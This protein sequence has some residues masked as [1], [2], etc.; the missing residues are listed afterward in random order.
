MDNRAIEP[1]AGNTSSRYYYVAWLAL[2]AAGIFYVTIATLAPELLRGADTPAG[3]EATNAQVTA[4]STNVT[5]IS[6]QV[7]ALQDKQKSMTGDISAVRTDVTGLQ[8]KVTDIDSLNHTNS[9][10]ISALEGGTVS[11]PGGPA[12]TGAVPQA[13]DAKP[14]TGSV[15][16]IVGEVVPADPS[17][18]AAPNP[19]AVKKPAKVASTDA[20]PKPYALD[21]SAVSTSNAALAELWSL[22][23][24]Q[25]PDV[26]TGLSPRS[27]AAG[28][29]VRLLAGPFSSQAAA[30]AACAKLRAQG[31]TCSPTPMAG[32]PL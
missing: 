13:I 6:G 31:V 1:A 4:L 9:T 22:F 16:A 24:D 28:S 2:G 21:L 15:P 10:R 5:Q 19:A 23:K 12:Q 30:A 18:G 20:K 17:V 25:H 29:N 26:L 14:A 7:A 32:T 11:A 3:M 27:V 8:A